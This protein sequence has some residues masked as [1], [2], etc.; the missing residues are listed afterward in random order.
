[1]DLAVPAT[2]FGVVF[3][4]ELP[5][6]TALASLIRGSRYRPVFVWAGVAAAFAVHTALAVTAGSLPR[7]SPAGPWKPWWRC[8][9]RWAP[10]SCSAAGASTASTSLGA[11]GS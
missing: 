9:S 3:L 7:C 5:D 6:K 1:V 8:C 11:G 4:A 2:V 10:R